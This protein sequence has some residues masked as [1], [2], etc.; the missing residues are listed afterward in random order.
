MFIYTAWVARITTAYTEQ[1]AVDFN[2]LKY[3]N[4]YQ[5]SI[6]GLIYPVI[7][8]I[9]KEC[10]LFFQ[11]LGWCQ[12]R[13]SLSLCWSWVA[14]FS[15]LNSKSRFFLLPRLFDILRKIFV[16]RWILLKFFDQRH[17]RV[18]CF[19]ISKVCIFNVLINLHFRLLLIF[20]FSLKVR[21]S[22]N[23]RV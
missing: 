16:S 5:R 13:L 21:C 18:S 7:L 17:G 3:L 8:V 4:L 15:P 2:V 11:V 6:I 22:S 14:Q 19:E 9:E 12:S 23:R 1:L 20:V 10:K